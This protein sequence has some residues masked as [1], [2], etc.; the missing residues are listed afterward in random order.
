MAHG[1]RLSELAWQQNSEHFYHR[2]ACK[3]IRFIFIRPPASGVGFRGLSYS[4]KHAAFLPSANAKVISTCVR[5]EG[6]ER[7]S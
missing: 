4:T 5:F 1:F 2:P 3:A 7:C 6:F